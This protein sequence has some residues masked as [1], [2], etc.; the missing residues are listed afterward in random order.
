MRSLILCIAY[1]MLVGCSEATLPESGAS[2][3][4]S[5]PSE[6]QAVIEALLDQFLFKPTGS[7][8]IYVIEHV[9]SLRGLTRE[10]GLDKLAESLRAAAQ[11]DSGSLPS[12]VE[13]LIKRNEHDTE[14]TLPT[15][16]FS[17]VRLISRDRINEIFSRDSVSTPKGWDLFYRE[18]PEAGGM[19]SISRPGISADGTVAIIYCGMQSHYLAGSGQLWVLELR[20]G[21]WKLTSTYIGPSWVS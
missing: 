4:S 11:R 12:A 2:K 1:F 5:L 7:D 17:R 10:D 15:E 18:Y 13:D 3:L 20:E 9:A 19:I 6:E 8:G 16:R 21:A 14:F